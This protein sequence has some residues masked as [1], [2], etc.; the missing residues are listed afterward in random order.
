MTDP[1]L[2]A[3]KRWIESFYAALNARDS[4]AV[5]AH[6]GP[7]AVLEV[8]VDGPF[9][10]VQ[11]A[12]REVLEA[13]FAAFSELHFTLLGLTAEGDRVAVEIHSKGT[14]AGGSSYSNRYHNLF[15]LRDGRIV[16]FREYPTG[17]TGNGK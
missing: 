10:G 16:S 9:G 1:A 13:F 11:P 8:F 17:Y 12:T 7:D 5:L 4:D 14:H 6:Y 3:N 15:E 2:A